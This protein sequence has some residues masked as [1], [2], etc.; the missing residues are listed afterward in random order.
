MV[1][2]GSPHAERA[3]NCIGAVA[4][5]PQEAE[6]EATNQILLCYTKPNP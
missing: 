4:G 2:A 1:S 3:D 6:Q 5:D